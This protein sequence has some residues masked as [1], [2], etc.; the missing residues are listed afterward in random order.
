[1]RRGIPIFLVVLILQTTSFFIAETKAQVK[2]LAE[3]KS[4]QE[5]QRILKL[6]IEVKTENDEKILNEMDL[7]CEWSK[8]I[9]DSELSR[10]EV[11]CNAT[12]NQMSQLKQAGIEFEVEREGIRIEKKNF[13][14]EGKKEDRGVVAGENSTNYSIPYRNWVYSPITIS[15]T[16]T[17]ATVYSI[18]VHFEVII[19]GWAIWLSI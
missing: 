15:S 14:F 11:V 17:G 9:D 2:D 13:H 4:K 8:D 18:D 3:T 7:K 16:P 12:V 10:T 6:R 19:P 1:M 5:I